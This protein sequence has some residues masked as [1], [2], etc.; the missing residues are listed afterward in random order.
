MNTTTLPVLK[1]TEPVRGYTVIES[2]MTAEA[3][4]LFDAAYA[5]ALE[6]SFEFSPETPAFLRRQAC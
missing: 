5:E 6:H 4:A 1:P 2:D 3:R